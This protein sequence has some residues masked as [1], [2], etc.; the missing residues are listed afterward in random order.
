MVLIKIFLEKSNAVAVRYLQMSDLLKPVLCFFGEDRRRSI[1]VLCYVIAGYYVTDTLVRSLFGLVKRRH[2]KNKIKANQEKCQKAKD[3][4]ENYLKELKASIKG[5]YKFE[6][7][8]GLAGPLAHY[9]TPFL[10]LHV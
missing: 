6:V 4:L 9:F 10:L 2:I 1:K 7:I 5:V 8:F 3:K